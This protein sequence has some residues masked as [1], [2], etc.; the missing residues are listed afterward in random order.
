MIK[1]FFDDHFVRH[2]ILYKKCSEST[3]ITKLESLEEKDKAFLNC[4]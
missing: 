4:H 3:E 1:K 2:E